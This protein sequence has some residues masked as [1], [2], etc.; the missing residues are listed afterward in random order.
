M[1]GFE[2]IWI[3]LRGFGRFV[4]V[5]CSSFH[6]SLQWILSSLLQICFDLGVSRV[7]FWPRLAIMVVVVLARCG[8]FMVD[9]WRLRGEVVATSRCGYGVVVMW[10]LRM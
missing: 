9:Q 6:L 2:R 5:W 10:C 1:I 3:G 8:G 7:T 4:R